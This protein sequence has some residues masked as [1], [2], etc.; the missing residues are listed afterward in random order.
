M[1]VANL[2]NVFMEKEYAMLEQKN[3]GKYYS[4]DPFCP[5]SK[6]KQRMS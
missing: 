4:I 3:S 2:K 1:I 6:S 5:K